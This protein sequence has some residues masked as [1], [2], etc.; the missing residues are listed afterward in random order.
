MV[1]L[2]HIILAQPASMPGGRV[3][4]NGGQV[5]VLDVKEND[6]IKEIDVVF[7]GSCE[8]QRRQVNDI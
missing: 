8:E 4:A 3:K 1:S 6:R 2:P 5:S 7:L